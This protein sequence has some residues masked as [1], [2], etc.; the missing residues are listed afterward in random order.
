MNKK[1]I[2]FLVC[3]LIIIISVVAFIMIFPHRSY[4]NDIIIESSSVNNSYNNSIANKISDSTQIGDTILYSYTRDVLD[5]GIFAIKTGKTKRVYWDGL[6]IY[7]SVPSLDIIYH[8]KVLLES[9]SDNY[10]DWERSRF[11]STDTQYSPHNKKSFYCFIKDNIRYFVSSDNKFFQQKGDDYI[12]IADISSANTD[13]SQSSSYITS[14]YI[15]FSD[16][17]NEH[18][19]LCQY[20]IKT[21]SIKKLPFEAGDAVVDSESLMGNGEKLIF[22]TMDSNTLFS[23]D[24]NTNRVDKLYQVDEGV[25]TVNMYKNNIYIGVRANKEKGLLVIPIDNKDSIS[26][27]S[28]KNIYGVYIFDN[29]YVYYQDENKNLFRVTTDGK[30]TDIV[31]DR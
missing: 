20:D 18:Y 15:Y 21:K 13:L 14:D 7:P 26:W 23:A 4:P 24:F 5:Y 9:N 11:V 19:C 3:M 16:Y 27:L 6:Q 30:R 1:R 17:E 31:F 2:V 28:R 10:F 22:L 25:L 12:L 29:N 8:D